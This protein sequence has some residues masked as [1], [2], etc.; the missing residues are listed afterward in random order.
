[1]NLIIQSHSSRKI[2]QQQSNGLVAGYDVITP[3]STI[4]EIGKLR[5]D[6]E[7]E[8]ILQKFPLQLFHRPSK[9][10]KSVSSWFREDVITEHIGIHNECESL[11]L[12]ASFFEITDTIQSEFRHWFSEFYVSHQI[13]SCSFTSI[14]LLCRQGRITTSLLFGQFNYQKYQW[15]SSR[16]WNFHCEKHCLIKA[17]WCA[18]NENTR[19][20]LDQFLKWFWKYN[21]AFPTL[22]LLLSAGS[23]FDSQTRSKLLQCG[24]DTHTLSQV[25]DRR[26]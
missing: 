25:H 22:C 3:P 8:K 5:N 7:F 9:R 13:V 24:G 16:C 10:K 12:K 20:N 2:L 18:L 23:S 11:N 26:P 15:R 6:A 19:M 4:T 1:M 14:E 17:S 21:A